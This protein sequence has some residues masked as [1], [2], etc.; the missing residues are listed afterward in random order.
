MELNLQSMEIHD[1]HVQQHHPP[2]Q[3]WF[4]TLVSIGELVSNE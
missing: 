1:K 2:N 4:Y 3:T